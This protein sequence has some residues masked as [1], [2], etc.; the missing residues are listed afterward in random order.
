MDF[1]GWIE[2]YYSEST[3]TIVEAYIRRRDHNISELN[4]PIMMLRCML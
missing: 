2:D 3:E 4:D 1:P